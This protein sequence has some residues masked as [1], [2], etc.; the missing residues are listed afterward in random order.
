MAAG[1]VERSMK[2]SADEAWGAV[3]DFEGVDKIFKDLES[4]EIVDGDRV[5]GLMGL[6]IREK[7]I[8]RDD[9]TRTITYSVVDGIPME[10][11]EA[12]ISVVEEGDGC[13]VTWTFD[14]SPDEMAPIFEATYTGALEAAAS[15]LEA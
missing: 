5:L 15:A 10:R 4:L 14:V 1:S 7:L 3:G 11:H 13:K 6:S 8:A 9:A 2:V 12:T